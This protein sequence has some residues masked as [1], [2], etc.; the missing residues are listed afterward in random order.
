MADIDA[1]VDTSVA[2]ALLV[3]CHEAHQL[4]LHAI[5]KRRLALP[6]HALVETYSVL[7]RL[8]GDAR[9]EPED[10]VQL[11]DRNFDAVL[12]PKPESIVRIHQLCARSGI[13]GGAVYD[14][15]V[16]IA[17]QDHQIELLTRDRRAEGTYQR[18]GIAYSLIGGVGSP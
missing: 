12:I 11:L 2:V 10:A 14:A 15:L 4:V 9:I 5:G 3:A 1:A 16:G 6:Q 8:P 7:T 13:A 17:A 18:L